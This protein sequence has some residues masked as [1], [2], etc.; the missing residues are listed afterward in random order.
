[1]VDHIDPPRAGSLFYQRDNLS[2][3]NHLQLCIIVK[4]SHRRC[5]SDKCKTSAIEAISSSRNPRIID[6]HLSWVKLP[7]MR[8]CRTASLRC[9]IGN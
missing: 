6:L 5:L 1:M 3:I 7:I 9:M 4:I 8:G 2:F